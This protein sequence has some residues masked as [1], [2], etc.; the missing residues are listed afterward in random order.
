MSKPIGTLKKEYWIIRSAN[1]WALAIIR[2]DIH[3][4][5][6]HVRGTHGS[7]EGPYIRFVDAQR[8]FRL[9]RQSRRDKWYR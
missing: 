4:A 5:Y 3:Q 2:G 7:I 6:A 8:D 1:G 9:L